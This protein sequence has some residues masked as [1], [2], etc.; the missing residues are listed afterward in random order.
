M[1]AALYSVHSQHI[2]QIQRSILRP[3]HTYIYIY[4]ISCATWRISIVLLCPLMGNGVVMFLFSAGLVS[5]LL[6]H[7]AFILAFYHDGGNSARLGLGAALYMYAAGIVY[8]ILAL[9][10][11]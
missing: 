7:V 4:I 5:F 11:K 6:G 3:V 10:N 1:C 8:V 2:V 9:G